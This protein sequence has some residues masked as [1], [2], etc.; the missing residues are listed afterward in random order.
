MDIESQIKIVVL[1][2]TLVGFIVILISTITILPMSYMMNKYIH[3]NV[4]V[5]WLMGIFGVLTGPFVLIYAMVSAIV[6]NSARP[7]YFGLFPSY[8]PMDVSK[9]APQSGGAYPVSDEEKRQNDSSMPAF[10]SPLPLPLPLPP[11]ESVP[12]S[13]LTRIYDLIL[14]LSSPI[15][16]FVD[17]FVSENF[18]V[19]NSHP[20]AAFKEH[21]NYI[22]GGNK[23]LPRFNTELMDAVKLAGVESTLDKW[24]GAMHSLEP[25]CAKLF[26]QA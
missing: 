12:K 16:M 11:S 13:W 23:N 14:Q 22:Y 5:R 15:S 10:P 20:Y 19:E 3:H 8:I 1:M 18:T 25:E 26:K 24:S 7:Y 6:Y 9:K 21:I 4:I 17:I 2:G